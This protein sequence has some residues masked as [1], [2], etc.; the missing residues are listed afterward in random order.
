MRYVVGYQDDD[1]GREA[2]AL[3]TSLARRRGAEL[4]IVLVTPPRGQ[5]FDQY[6]P[7]RVYR[8]TMDVHAK[9]VLQ[10]AADQVPPQVTTRTHLRHADST[11]TGL[12]EMAD[13]LGAGLVVVGAGRGA[14]LHRFTLGSVANALLHSAT[15]PVALAPRGYQ[16]VDG[17]TRITAAIGERAGAQALLDVAVE[18]AAAR[19]VELRLISLV[20]LDEMTPSTRLAA[21]AEQ[22]EQ[23][24]DGARRHA[25]A[26]ASRSR[27]VLPATVPVTTAVGHGRSIESAV[28]SLEFDSTEIVFVGSSRLAATKSIFLGAVANKILRSLPVPM[29][30]VPR[31]YELPAGHP[32]TQAFI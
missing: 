10:E 6:S 31:D 17:M 29:V 7:N 14:L 13:E 20:D 19:S 26:L 16:E 25:D 9:E 28:S 2:I 15:T 12:I 1:R 22:Q 8:T 4:D 21:D 24:L 11:T 27:S 3:A 18:S 32:S 5:T 23:V 30:V